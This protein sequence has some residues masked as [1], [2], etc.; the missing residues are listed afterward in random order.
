MFKLLCSDSHG[1]P[2]NKIRK[3]VKLIRIALRN[4]YRIHEVR[5]L[6]RSI[7]ALNVLLA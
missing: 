5:V 7:K 6:H 2:F 3:E 1:P 4:L